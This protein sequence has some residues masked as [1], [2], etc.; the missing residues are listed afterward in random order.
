MTYD[1]EASLRNSVY[2]KLLKCT[3]LRTNHHLD[4]TKRGL[5]STAIE[6]NEYRSLPE[7][8]E[9]RKNL[10]RKIHNEFGD[11]IYE[12]PGFYKELS[13]DFEEHPMIIGGPHLAIP[14]RNKDR[15]LWSLYLRRD[16]ERGKNKY[17]HFSKK[18]GPPLKPL[19]HWPMGAPNE[20]TVI[21]TEG[22]LKADVVTAITGKLAIALP[23]VGMWKMLERIIAENDFKEYIVANDRDLEINQNVARPTVALFRHLVQKEKNVKIAVWDNKHKG[24]DD[25]LVNNAE[26]K[27]LDIP[28]AKEYFDK[29]FQRFGLKPIDWLNTDALE[30]EDHSREWAQVL[31][32]PE[33]NIQAPKFHEELLPPPLRDWVLDTADRM[34]A[35]AE[36]ILG[37]TLVLLSG[38]IGRRLAIRPKKMD[39]WTVIVNL[40]GAIVGRPSLL[41]TP[42]ISQARRPMDTIS[43]ELDEKFESKRIEWKAA[44]ATFLNQKKSIEEQIKKAHSKGEMGR[45]PNF[46][47]QLEEIESAIENNRPRRQRLYVNDTTVEMVQEIAKENKSGFVYLRDELYGLIKSLEK[48][49]REGDRAFLLEAWNGFGRYYVDRVGRGSFQLEALCIALLGGIQPEPLRAYLVQGAEDGSSDDGFIQRFQILLW[50]EIS[51]A[52]TYV[53]RNPDHE[54]YVRVEALF[55]KIAQLDATAISK[56]CDDSEVPYLHFNSEAQQVFH[57]WLMNLEFRLRND[58]PEKSALESHLGKYRSLMPSLALIF[59]LLDILD[60]SPNL[61]DLPVTAEAARRAVMW[62]EFLEGHAL[63]VYA[64]AVS[65]AVLGAKELKLK[66]DER[67]IH[68]R[69]TIREVYR[70]GWTYLNNKAAVE[71]AC[72]VLEAH[73]WARINTDKNTGGAPSQWIEIN[74][75]AIDLNKYRQN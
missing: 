10:A 12:V 48:P 67:K 37:P 57:D 2:L 66:I 73:G 22:P 18:D 44:E 70:H 50:P 23:G 16:N 4:L 32:L 63:K 59:H 54:A 17:I 47:R 74:P 53:D 33:T 29:I 15:L 40:W 9:E 69:M 24:I 27:Y 39:N 45:I 65:E 72:E 52:F 30:I 43:K 11:A 61:V 71:A 58:P 1:I 41:K 36:F 51:P 7:T 26:I 64:N 42:C 3:T 28:Q 31:P 38:L 21:F 13:Q 55:R 60:S 56:R 19:P 68:T 5:T 8:Y 25:A 75:N 62:C 35:Q 49:G 34:Q 46:R 14:V 6:L 20:S